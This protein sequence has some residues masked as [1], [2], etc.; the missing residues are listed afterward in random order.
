MRFTQAL[1]AGAALFA[2][3]FAAQPE[4]NSLTPENPK[5]GST[6]T[7]KYTSPNGA[8][9][10]TTFILS[11]GDPKA[12]SNISTLTTSATGGTFVWNVDS[13]LA[14]GDDYTLRIIQAN[15]PQNFW[16]QFAIT[17]GKD[18]VSSASSSASATASASLTTK[19]S[20]ASASVSTSASSNGTV[21]SATL[22]SSATGSATGRPSS[23]GSATGGG[24]GPPQSTGAAAA[25]GSKP[26]A[27]I[28][29]VVGAIAY[30]H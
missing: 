21:S 5:A 19:V 4:I 24:N 11:K 29:G 12:L 10:P 9:V 25:L 22:S 8:N 15:E 16:V 28:A 30:I 1:F 3:A 20:S 6:A 18:A 27:L 2:A 26:F 13:S 14:N 17:G 7:I 23:T